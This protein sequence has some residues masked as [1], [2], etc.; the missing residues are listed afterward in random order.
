MKSTVDIHVLK[1]MNVYDFLSL[2]IPHAHEHQNRCARYQTV[3]GPT[4]VYSVF[5]VVNRGIHVA[6]SVKLAAT[7][8]LVLR[9]PLTDPSGVTCD[10][11][12]AW[13]YLSM[14]S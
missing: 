14:S 11:M 3:S 13:L 6:H 4:R 10:A 1:R 12:A 8:T 7:K 2:K 5:K 9:Q